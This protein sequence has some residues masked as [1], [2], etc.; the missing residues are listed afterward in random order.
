[1]GSALPTEMTQLG[2]SK[3][4]DRTFDLVDNLLSDDE[5]GNMPGPVS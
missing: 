1:M 4:V 5:D 3:L 2:A